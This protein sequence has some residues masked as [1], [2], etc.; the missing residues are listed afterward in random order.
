MTTGNIPTPL[1][2]AGTSPTPLLSAANPYPTNV[3]N[4]LGTVVDSS[5]FHTKRF[6]TP[7]SL[8][9]KLNPRRLATYGFGSNIIGSDPA[10]SGPFY[11]FITTPD[12]NITNETAIN[13]LGLGQPT[14]PIGL[15]SLLTGGTG[16]IKLL[17]N[18]VQNFSTQDVVLDIH[19]VG[20]TFEGAKLTTPKS[21]LNSRQDGTLQLEYQ[22]Y[23]GLPVTLLHKIWIDYIEAVTRGLLNPKH[24]VPNYISLRILDYASSVYAIQTQADGST[25]EFGVRF[26]G[27]FPTAIPTSVWNG[28]MGGVDNIKVT[29]PYAY[30]FMEPMDPKIFTEFN[31]S[32]GNPSVSII[33]TTLPQSKRSVY[34]LVFTEGLTHTG[35]A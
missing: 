10:S 7:D 5:D 15:A 16:I 20:E 14:A 24:T 27:L 29:I 19:Q 4:V 12:I 21:T 6:V 35:L 26:T 33:Q 17:S 9:T 23:Q 30:S 3:S 31:I 34:K 28:R 32:V 11:V 2:D 8:T 22:E 18:L 13:F 25:I 1:L